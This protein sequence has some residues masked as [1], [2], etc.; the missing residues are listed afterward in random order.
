MAATPGSYPINALFTPL[1]D[2]TGVYIFTGD[3]TKRSTNCIVYGFSKTRIHAVVFA[4]PVECV[5]MARDLQLRPTLLKGLPYP[6]DQ[7]AK[8]MLSTGRKITEQAKKI[9]QALAEGTYVHAE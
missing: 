5:E 8:S 4:T 9:L 2:K 3:P 6:I 1:M 7:A